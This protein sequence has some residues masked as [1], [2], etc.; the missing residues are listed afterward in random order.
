MKLNENK[1]KNTIVKRSFGNH[2]LQVLYFTTKEHLCWW[3]KSKSERS[4]G[5]GGGD[6]EPPLPHSLEF[7]KYLYV[8]S[9]PLN[10]FYFAWWKVLKQHVFE[11]HSVKHPPPTSPKKNPG[12]APDKVWLHFIFSFTLSVGARLLPA[13]HPRRPSP[14]SY[15]WGCC[16]WRPPWYDPIL[17]PYSTVICSRCLRPGRQWWSLDI[18]E[19]R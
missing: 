10:I 6:L 14:L 7:A 11:G 9:K 19:N 13:V 15:R 5:G 16:Q 17:C 12:S 8:H 4:W 18:K 1:K 2:T 3:F